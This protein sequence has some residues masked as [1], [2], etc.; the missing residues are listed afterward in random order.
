[1]ISTTV[2]APSFLLMPNRSM[3]SCCDWTGSA[4]SSYLM[5]VGS[6]FRYS[7]RRLI[8]WSREQE[9]PFQLNP[10]SLRI[11]FNYPMGSR[12]PIWWKI[13]SIWELLITSLI[14]IELLPDRRWSTIADR[15][16]YISLQKCIICEGS[17]SG[18][19]EIAEF[20]QL[21]YLLGVADYELEILDAAYALAVRF[22][23]NTL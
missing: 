5:Y 8:S 7:L 17:N 13:L 4:A 3:L 21:D 10:I 18:S 15:S 20:T 19:L 1:M 22:R 23:S 14:D 2:C 11:A 12:Y 9:A 16:P 6:G